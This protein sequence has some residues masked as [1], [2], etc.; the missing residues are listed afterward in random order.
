MFN[1]DGVRI[2]DVANKTVVGKEET[3]TYD[4]RRGEGVRKK[5]IYFSFYEFVG[6]WE[7]TSAR[8]HRRKCWTSIVF[9]GR[10]RTTVTRILP[11]T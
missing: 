10:G 2:R 6:R 1:I 11:V 8:E 9:R 4:V 7:P 3:K 5:T